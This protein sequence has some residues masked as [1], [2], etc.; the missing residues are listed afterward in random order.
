MPDD[1]FVF[2]FLKIF[3]IWFSPFLVWILW[4][5]LKLCSLSVVFHSL[6][7]HFSFWK[8]KKGSLFP[9]CLSLCL[10]EFF[11]LTKSFISLLLNLVPLFRDFSWGVIFLQRFGKQCSRCSH[12]IH[13]L[14]YH[15]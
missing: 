13:L 2:H 5:V 8:E 1:S 6:F 12:C 15:F 14:T 3:L 11:L 9:M 4:V 7:F 10:L